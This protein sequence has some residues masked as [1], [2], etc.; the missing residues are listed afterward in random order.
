[1]EVLATMSA[2][3]VQ[4]VPLNFLQPGDIAR[5]VNGIAVID[6]GLESASVSFSD[7]SFLRSKSAA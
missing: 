3:K 7:S 5:Q 1:M 4:H 6:D 2:E